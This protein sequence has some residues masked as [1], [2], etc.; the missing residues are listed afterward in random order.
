MP[1]NKQENIKGQLIKLR[2]IVRECLGFEEKPQVV[3]HAF[4]F[5]FWLLLDQKLVPVAAR[6]RVRSMFGATFETK[7]DKIHKYIADIRQQL[8][9]YEL[10]ELRQWNRSVAAGSNSENWGENIIIQ[11]KTA[12]LM[13]V[14]YLHDLAPTAITKNQTA[15]GFSM[16]WE[17]SASNA[18]AAAS[19]NN[20][21]KLSAELEELLQISERTGDTQLFAKLSE[22]L[23]SKRS[24]EA[25]QNDLIEL[26]G[27]ECFELVQSLLTQ[28]STFAL[29][30]E[31]YENRNKRLKQSQKLAE[32]VQRNGQELR[33]TVASA[34]IV[35]SALEKELSKQQRR[36]EKKIQRMMN[37]LGREGGDNVEVA[38]ALDPA[39][40]RLQQQRRLLEAAQQEPLLKST[41]RLKEFRPPAGYVPPK[42]PYVFDSQLGAKQ[43]AGFIGGN[44]I[45]LPENATRHDN[46]QYEEVNIPATEPPPLTIGNNRIQIENLD[47]IGKLA[48]ANCKELNRI[49][50]VVY[51]VAYHSNENMLVCA[52]TGAGKTN[53]AMLTIVHTIR[54]HLENG[55]INR[56]QFKIVYIAPMKALASEMV[57][58]FSKRLKSLDIVVK[59][60]TGDMQ[61]SKT[62]MTQTQILVTTPE[63]WDVVTRKGMYCGVY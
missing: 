20:A 57:D 54:Q 51:S 47:D 38:R 32:K 29:Q 42:Y 15:L 49:Q 39:Q 22:M 21:S 50:S 60:L 53:V 7:L 13:P 52:P 56:D 33:P 23:N 45:T 28:R 8:E 30:L 59:E 62:E 27:F 14:E 9:D 24:N 4:L 40:L 61:L 2:K 10:Q 5:L 16:Q 11:R 46:R 55:L 37:S 25:L 34:V 1:I 43:H 63:K 35:Q 3:E 48:F 26:L 58:N 6:L 17:D 36:E 41:Q 18:A 19:V 31:Q 44:R 12:E